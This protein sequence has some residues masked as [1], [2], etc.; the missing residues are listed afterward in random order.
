[1]KAVKLER[2]IQQEIRI[3]SALV[4]ELTL[5]RNSTGVAERAGR[6]LRYGLCR[7]S[8]DLIGILAPTGRLCAW[9]CKTEVGRLSEEQ[10]LFLAHVRS[11]GGFACVVRSVEEFLESV[12]RAKEG[13]SE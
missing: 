11:R 13:L 10:R 3:A 6:T 9:E 12:K 7:G 4:P 5:W 2:N 1:M 8:S